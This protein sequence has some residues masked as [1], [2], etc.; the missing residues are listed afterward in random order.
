M[1]ENGHPYFEDLTRDNIEW[2][3]ITYD[4]IGLRVSI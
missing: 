3:K 2:E 4:E 1:E